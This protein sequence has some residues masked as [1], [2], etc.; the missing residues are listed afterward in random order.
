MLTDQE[1]QEA[2]AAFEA[3]LLAEHERIAE[4]VAARKARRPDGRSR[5]EVEARRIELYELREKVRLR[6]YKEHGYRRYIDST[7][8]EVWLTPEEFALRSKR[9]S[10]RRSHT[11]EQALPSKYRTVALYVG[12]ALLALVLGFALAR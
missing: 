9:R 10:R 5:Q 2:E 6:F 11:L 8:R 1:R 7:G 4:S 3:E 12:L